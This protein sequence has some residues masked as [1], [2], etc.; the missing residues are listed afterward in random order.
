M[1]DLLPKFLHYHRMMLL[2]AFLQ[3]PQYADD[4]DFLSFDPQH[5]EQV[6]EVCSP[7]QPSIDTGPSALEFIWIL[8]ALL[9]MAMMPG[10]RQRP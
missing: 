10:G 3:K 5:L 9:I 6:L 1:R 8:K 7:S 2:E 4:L